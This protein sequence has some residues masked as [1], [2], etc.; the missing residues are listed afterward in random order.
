MK[1]CLVDQNIK[2]NVKSLFR[3]FLTGRPAGRVFGI[4]RHDC[5]V[6]VCRPLCFLC[7]SHVLQTQG[8]SAEEKTC[9]CVVL[10][11]A[12]R[13]R[14][15]VRY[16]PSE[17]RR[18]APADVAG[19]RRGDCG[20]WHL[21]V[22]NLESGRERGSLVVEKRSIEEQQQRTWQTATFPPTW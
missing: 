11:P 21:T 19:G 18:S 7:G 8:G 13:R 5:L 2:K 1:R 6:V 12:A 3:Q 17:L 14:G 4:K 22:I 9:G 20:G 10:G 15:V 16:A